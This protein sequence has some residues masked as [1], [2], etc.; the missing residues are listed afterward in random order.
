MK[1][2]VDNMGITAEVTAAAGIGGNVSITINGDGTAT[3]TV[4]FTTGAAFE[5]GIGVSTSPSA[6][7]D[8]V[9]VEICA[10]ASAGISGSGCISAPM[11]KDGKLYISGKGGVG[12]GAKISETT[13][14]Q[15]T[16][17]IKGGAAQPSSPYNSYYKPICQVLPPTW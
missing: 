1:N 11:Q 3:I 12:L 6:T 5:G 14:Y 13:G 2:I 4:G 15:K 10:G 17:R 8:G 9:F 7:P 16:I